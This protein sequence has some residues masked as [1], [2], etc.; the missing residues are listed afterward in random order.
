MNSVF[1][2]IRTLLERIENSM[3]RSVIL[4]IINCTFV[5]VNFIEN[6]CDN[7]DFVNKKINEVY[8]DEI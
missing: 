8:P 5:R 3:S 6:Q 4:K 1:K 2:F 7:I